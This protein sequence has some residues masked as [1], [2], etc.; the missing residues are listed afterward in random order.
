MKKNEWGY[1][2]KI[3]MNPPFSKQ[4]DIDHIYKAF[5]HL[6]REGILISIVSEAPFFRT[7][8]KSIEF[9][10]FLEDNNAEIIKKPEGTFK[11]RGTMVNT[12]LI[13]ITG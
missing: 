2:D 12:R 10:K 8:K 11:E 6:K 13:K 1:F 5:W 7:N 3:I 4:Q 9:R